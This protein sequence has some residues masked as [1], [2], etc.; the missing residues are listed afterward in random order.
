VTKTFTIS[1]TGS[2]ALTL[3]P[4]LLVVPDGFSVVAPFATSVAA[5]ASTTLV[6]E[7]DATQAGSYSGD[8]S[9]AD[10]DPNNDPFA[11]TVT[12]TVNPPL[13]AV[14][15]LSGR[16][17]LVNEAVQSGTA[18]DFGSTPQGTPV[19]QT[20][21]VENTGT[22]T[23]TLDPDSLSLPDGF[24][25]VT[26]FAASVAPGASTTLVVQLDGADAGQYA[27]DIE[28]SDNDPANDPFLISVSGTVGRK[29]GEEKV[30]ATKFDKVAMNR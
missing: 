24:S 7:L 29:R 13:P 21:T 23:L 2:A 3:N 6:L 14:E 25:V 10:N 20:F 5:G 12:G 8:V 9:F 30:P 27:G 1:N 4:D 17:V 11:F 28:F 18:V 15:V 26:P 19:A 16:T 22:A